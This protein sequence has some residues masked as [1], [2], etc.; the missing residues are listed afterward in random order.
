LD[1]PASG[2]QKLHVTLTP[3][4]SLDGV[5]TIYDAAGGELVRADLNSAGG[6]ES[7]TFNG[8]IPNTS[9]YLRIGSW[10][11]Q[12]PGSYTLSIDFELSLPTSM[13]SPEGFA[14]FH[15]DGTSHDTQTFSGTTGQAYIDYDS[16]VDSFYF[17][18]EWAGTYTVT[19]NALS[20]SVDP[21][22]ALY[23][24]ST[25]NL[26]GFDHNSGGGTSA[27]LGL[28]LDSFHRY[29][30]AVADNDRSGTGDVAIIIDGPGNAVPDVIAVSSSGAGTGSGTISAKEDTDYYCF[31]S[32]AWANGDLT[33]TVTPAPSLNV[34]AVLFDASGHELG[35]AYLLRAGVA[36][37][38]TVTGLAPSTTYYLSVLSVDY[39]TSGSFGVSVQFGGSIPSGTIYG[40]KYEDLNGNGARDPGEPGRQGWRI[41]VDADGDG[42]FD[43]RHDPSALSDSSGNYLITNLALGQTHFVYEVPQTGW[44]LSDPAAGYYAVALNQFD[45]I[46]NCNFGNFRFATIEGQKWNDLDGDGF[47][48]GGEPVLSGWTIYADLDGS[49]A[50]DPGEPWDTTDGAGAYTLE[51][52]R[53]G[54]WQI[55]EEMQSGWVQRFPALR[56][57]EVTVTSGA[58]L[59]AI[60]FGNQNLAA[61]IGDIFS[62]AEN[63]GLGA[64][65]FQL[66]T[67]IGDGLYGNE[68]VDMYKLSVVG[69]TMLTA[70]TSLPPGGTAMDTVL[71]LFDSN[72]Q[73]AINDDIVP[74][75]N[76]YSRIQY[77]FSSSGTYYIG[78]SGYP[79]SAYNPQVVGQG[80]PGSTGSYRLL[81]ETIAP[82]DF[83]DAPDPTYATLSSS[84][85]ASHAISLSGPWLGGPGDA[86]DGEPDGQPDAHAAG[87]DLDTGPGNP[88]PNF[89][90]ENGVSAPVLY[91]GQQAL[92]DVHISHPTGVG[93]HLNMWIDFDR[94]GTWSGA[95]EKVFGQF[96]PVG[97]HS[98]AVN[99]PAG[100]AAGLTFLRARISTQ[101]A[102]YYWGPAADGEVEDHEVE[103]R[104]VPP[105][106]DYGDAPGSYSTLAITAGACHVIG[107]PWLGGQDDMPDPEPD[108]QPDSNAAGDDGDTDPLNPGPNYDDENGVRVPVMHPGQPVDISVE[109]SDPLSVGG[110]LDMW[111]DWNIDGSWNGPG[112]KVYGGF[113][114]VGLHPITVNV[115]A[116]LTVL[117]PTYVRARISTQGG[118]DYWGPAPDGEVEDLLAYIENVLP[119]RDYGDAPGSTYCTLEADLGAFHMIAGPWLGGEDDVPDGEPD[120]QPHAAALG[121]DRDVDPGNPLPNYDDENGVAAPVLLVGRP[122]LINVE[123][124]DPGAVGAYLD[125]W[126]DFDRDGTW[127]GTNEKVFAGF[128]PPG[129]HALA[130]N[131]PAGAAIGRTFLRARLSSQGGL[132][133]WGPSSDGE[134]ED[135]M[136]T[137]AAPPPAWDFGDAPDPTYPTLLASNGARHLIGGPWLG[138]ANDAPDDE[139]D[140]QPDAR[141]RGDDKLAGQN[142]PH[143]PGDD[144]NGVTAPLLI[145]GQPA[146]IQVEVSDPAGLGGVVDVWIDFNRDGTW[147]GRNEHVFSGFL[148]VGIHGIPI[149][150]PA[151]AAAAQTFLRAR[152]NSQGALRYDGPANDGEVEDH[153]V[154]ISRPSVV[155]RWVF[156]NGSAF[157]G[158]NAAANAQDDNAIPTNKSALLPGGIATF[159]NYTSYSRGINGIMVDIVGLANPTGLNPTDF[160]FKVGND[161]NPDGPGWTT[162]PNPSVATRDL[163]NGVT[164]VTLIWADNDAV[165]NKWLQVTVKVTP[166]TGLA[167][168]DVFYFGNAI[169]ETGNNAANAVVDL[170]DDLAARAHKTGFTPAAITNVYDFNRDRRVNATDELISRYNHSGGN[171]LRLIDLSGEGGGLPLMSEPR[172]SRLSPLAAS[173][174][175]VV[176]VTNAAAHDTILAAPAVQKPRG[177][178]DWSLQWAWLAEFEQAQIKRPSPKKDNGSQQALD[179]VLAAYEG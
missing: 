88:A 127:N 61:D 58:S 46:A 73:L 155:G 38:I 173:P 177:A 107:G 12:T 75:V 172:T 82:W 72:R 20:G 114:P 171:A 81:L 65:Q 121:D 28:N 145:A 48:D 17:A 57:H 146:V 49:G 175:P 33:V 3:G 97:T 92:I 161:S 163:G 53:P 32:P 149:N 151:D 102:R 93:G 29:I 144:E 118:L 50:R 112:E 124:F 90:D 105:E 165:K 137:I 143:L 100:A 103:I 70:E 45:P 150:V 24:A 168:S 8:A 115:P 7:I 60:H 6:A 87:D 139:P 174:V 23:D 104:E 36:E 162:A 91:A 116:D 159:A 51:G 166:N 15:N 136:V 122:A 64:G 120:G 56:Y 66:D 156:Y 27:Q 117:G 19:V 26:L 77:T 10:R 126:I 2:T 62:T 16:D 128:L 34:A 98:I 167:A 83:G 153:A 40:T 4:A 169:G 157:D 164:R 41:Y 68:D 39:Q 35:S 18:G 44:Q 30:V 94:D 176:A 25:G 142:S 134:V 133:W 135:Y 123:V 141:A 9:Y 106:W 95:D 85:G 129:A 131:V 21:V 74:R 79:N 111:I 154:F 13:T 5:L 78:V 96:L 89:D 55:R 119:D 69:G 147:S 47:F 14:Y 31:T 67:L 110:V 140:G 179:Q 52:V 1:V 160:Q 132:D 170:Q 22:L 37:T 130:V 86:P 101:G 152:I 108:G 125:M 178:D 43:L 148:P 113:L 63:T 80:Q 109:V 11:Y 158:N 59:T 42:Q 84:N 76:L 54:T 71:R 99:V 138:D